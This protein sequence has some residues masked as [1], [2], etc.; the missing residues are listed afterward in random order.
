MIR[1]QQGD[2]D[3]FIA[4]SQVI[5]IYLLGTEIRYTARDLSS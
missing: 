1:L 5:K 3:F 4:G 2:T